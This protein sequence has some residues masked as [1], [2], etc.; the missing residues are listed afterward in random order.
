MLQQAER[1]QDGDKQAYAYQQLEHIQGYSIEAKA[2][3]Y[4]MA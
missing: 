3:S 2:A 1:D 4:S